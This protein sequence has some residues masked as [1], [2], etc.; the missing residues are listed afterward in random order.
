M[1][2]R[3]QAWDGRDPERLAASLRS[4]ASEPD[5]LAAAVAET[6]ARVEAEG[7][8]AVAELSV[9]FDGVAADPV[10]VPRDRLTAALA[11]IASRSGSASRPR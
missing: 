1:K 8:A 4:A 5:G 7:D 6:I 3:M 10:E 2:I 11:S 9:R